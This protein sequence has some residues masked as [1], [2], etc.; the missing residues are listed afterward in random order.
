MHF[1][2]RQLVDQA[3]SY[4]VKLQKA[5]IALAVIDICGIIVEIIGKSWPALTVEVLTIALGLLGFW[6]AYSRKRPAVL[7]YAVINI[8]L[9]VFSV[10]VGV[11]IVFTIVLVGISL[12]HMVVTP[13]T[14]TA[15]GGG[16]NPGSG[17]NP[18]NPSHHASASL[19]TSRVSLADGIFA[20]ALG[21]AE[22]VIRIYSISLA[23]RVSTLL[24]QGGGARTVPVDDETAVT[25]VQMQSPQFQVP[26]QQQ[27]QQQQQQAPQQPPGQP[28]MYFAAQTPNGIQYFF[29]PP[30]AM[31][32]TMAAPPGYYQ[33][34][35]QMQPQSPQQQ[36]QPQ[37]YPVSVALPPP[38]VAV[39]ALGMQPP[40]S[41]MPPGAPAAPVPQPPQQPTIP[42]P[43][44]PLVD[45]SLPPPN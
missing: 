12:A 13:D 16:G 22:L 25:S 24:K 38:P 19:M 42:L 31:P 14:T 20:L 33:V 27:Q 40:T 3:G 7:A 45:V 32:Q 8:I 4:A 17:S 6:G 5:I 37:F 28:L 23:L 10:V 41:S 9:L 36:Q 34:S 21:I 11:I 18:T 26:Q 29:A 44:A 1:F 43:P 15:V 30:Q 2:Q 39:P 35:P